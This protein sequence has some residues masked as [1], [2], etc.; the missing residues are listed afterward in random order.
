MWARNLWENKN[1]VKSY[2]RVQVIFADNLVQRFYIQISLAHTMR[3][4]VLKK[5]RRHEVK[6]RNLAT[7]DSANMIL[8]RVMNFS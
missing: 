1:H 5:T 2:G 7:S 3:I 8:L 4:R 6:I